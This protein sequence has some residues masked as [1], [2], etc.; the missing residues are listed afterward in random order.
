MDENYFSAYTNLNFN[1]YV[2]VK[3]IPHKELIYEMYRLL[4]WEH[5]NQKYTGF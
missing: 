5:G 1:E 3:Y 2:G 4:H